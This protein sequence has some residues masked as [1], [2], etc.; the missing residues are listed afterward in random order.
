MRSSTRS[1]WRQANCPITA[2]WSAASFGRAT[3]RGTIGCGSH[4]RCGVCWRGGC[5]AR[6]DGEDADH[7]GQEAFVTRLDGSKGVER[8]TKAAKAI[9]REHA[10]AFL[11]G[12]QY[13]L[14]VLATPLVPRR[15][16]S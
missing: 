14:Y 7:S 12:V 2:K 3:S 10:S 11:L 15:A 8:V 4:M 6:T 9:G 1:R 16:V 13:P 5:W